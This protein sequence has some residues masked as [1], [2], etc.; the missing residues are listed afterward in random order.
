MGK[1]TEDLNIKISD[2]DL[3]QQSSFVY[4]GGIPPEFIE[5]TDGGLLVAWPSNGKPTA[6]HE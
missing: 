2:I 3:T 5:E 4:T 6:E 1:D